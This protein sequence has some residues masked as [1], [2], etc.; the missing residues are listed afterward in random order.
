MVALAVV[1]FKKCDHLREKRSVPRLD[2]QTSC[3]VN[4]LAAGLVT[5]TALEVRGCRPNTALPSPAP[6]GAAGLP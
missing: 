1:V 5:V 3:A 6:P 2:S 4:I